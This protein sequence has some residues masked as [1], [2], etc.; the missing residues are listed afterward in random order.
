MHQDIE[1]VNPTSLKPKPI[2][3]HESL[4]L[5]ST[6]PSTQ[7]ASCPDFSLLQSKYTSVFAKITQ[8]VIGHDADYSSESSEDEEEGG[9]NRSSFSIENIVQP[10]GFAYRYSGKPPP[11]SSNTVPVR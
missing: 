2:T 7:Q 10:K 6:I 11:S 9:V 8:Q 5:P 3:F 1:N 4:S